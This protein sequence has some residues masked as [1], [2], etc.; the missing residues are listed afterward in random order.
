MRPQ[1]AEE[2]MLKSNEASGFNFASLVA[3]PRSVTLEN[4]VWNKSG[5]ETGVPF[6][7]GAWLRAL[8]RPR[9]AGGPC[10]SAVS[11]QLCYFPH[12]GQPKEGSPC[13]EASGRSV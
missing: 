6:R 3:S 12:P 5:K 1:I 9:R 2:A 13:P 8:V 10:G 11:E 4:A 7:V